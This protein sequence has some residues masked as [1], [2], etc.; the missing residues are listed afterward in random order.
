MIVKNRRG[1]DIS[2]LSLGT[3]QLGLNY[4]INNAAGKPDEETAFALLQTACDGG[5]TVDRYFFG[6]WNQ[7]GSR[8]QIL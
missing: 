7:R 8:G 6:L 5:I 3:A 2:A 1:L 4:G